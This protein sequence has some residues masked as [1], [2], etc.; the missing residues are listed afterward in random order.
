MANTC[1]FRP[2]FTILNG[3]R[4][5]A[6]VF[7][8]TRALVSFPR[9]T[10]LTAAAEEDPDAG[11]VTPATNPAATRTKSMATKRTRRPPS[12]RTF[13][14]GS[15]VQDVEAVVRPELVGKR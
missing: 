4:P 3:I 12:P 2:R 13:T 10:T 6:N 11:N 15:Y 14:V 1:A 9:T 8:A 7:G 5:V